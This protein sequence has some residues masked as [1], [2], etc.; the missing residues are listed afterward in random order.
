MGGFFKP[1]DGCCAW[2]VP[3]SDPDGLM[4]PGLR[5][6]ATDFT[7]ATDGLGVSARPPATPPPMDSRAVD[8]RVD[9]EEVF[10]TVPTSPVGRFRSML[11][12]E[13]ARGCANRGVE[14]NDFREMAVA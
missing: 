10:F 1:I 6:A 2:G 13:L 11:S 9:A 5:S 4:L 8:C 3:P 7:C 14:T 12:K